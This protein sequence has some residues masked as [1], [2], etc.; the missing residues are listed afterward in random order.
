MSKQFGRTVW[1][2]GGPDRELSG[3]LFAKLFRSWSRGDECRKGRNVN[4][5]ANGPKIQLDTA[6]G[7]ALGAMSC[8]AVEDQSQIQKIPPIAAAPEKRKISAQSPV[9]SI[10]SSLTSTRQLCAQG[11]YPK[12]LL[13]GV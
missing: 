1:R 10:Q 7:A 11:M 2:Q 5:P 3:G 13:G 12:R 6:T 8:T 4:G 9:T